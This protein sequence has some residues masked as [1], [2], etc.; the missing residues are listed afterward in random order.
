[1]VGSG[2]ELVWA[3]GSQVTSTDASIPGWML[4]WYENVPAE[5]KV[6]VAVD[7]TPSSFWSNMPSGWPRV[8]DVTVC[9][10][11]SV[12]VHVTVVPTATFTGLGWNAKVRIVTPLAAGAVVDGAVVDAVVVAGAAESPEPLQPVN[13]RTVTSAAAAEN[14]RELRT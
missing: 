2:A 8:P 9:R 5:R 11:W 13:T 7:P 14:L 10:I 12:F 1:M 3:T 4:Q 6:N